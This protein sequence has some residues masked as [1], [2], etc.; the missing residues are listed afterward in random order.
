MEPNKTIPSGQA[1][2]QR[3]LRGR[4][5]LFFVEL[6]P[7][8][9]RKYL[10]LCLHLYQKN[11]FVLPW[12]SQKMCR[13][14]ISKGKCLIPLICGE[15]T[16]IAGTSGEAFHGVDQLLK[17]LRLVHVVRVRVSGAATGGWGSISLLDSHHFSTHRQGSSTQQD[18]TH[19]TGGIREKQGLCFRLVKDVQRV[20]CSGYALPTHFQT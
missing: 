1:K 5:W 10:T 4:V 7:S 9:S 3:W 20:Y 18:T 15:G 6:E 13:A 17:L 14:K 8:H 12:D 19:T 2:D 16:P 11:T